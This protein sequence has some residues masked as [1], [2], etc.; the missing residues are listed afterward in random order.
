L[1]VVLKILGLELQ[2]RV[3]EGKMWERERRIRMGKWGEEEGGGF[4][5]ELV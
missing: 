1:G 3:R 2:V 4:L 5:V